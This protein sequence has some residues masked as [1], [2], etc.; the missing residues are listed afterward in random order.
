MHRLLHLPITSG[1]G[2][3][4]VVDTAHE[5]VDLAHGVNVSRISCGLNGRRLT[6]RLH[7]VSRA[8]IQ[9]N[10]MLWTYMPRTFCF[11]GKVAWET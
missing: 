4:D 5:A 8:F 1:G 3:S 2:L 9:S 7:G 6:C 10:T 11:L